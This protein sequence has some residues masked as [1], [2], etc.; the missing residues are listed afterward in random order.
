MNDQGRSVRVVVKRSVKYCVSYM[1]RLIP[2]AYFVK[3]LDSIATRYNHIQTNRK[4][5]LSFPR[6]VNIFYGIMPFEEGEFNGQS[7]LLPGGW[8]QHLRSR[9]GDYMQL[10]PEEERLG[11]RPYLLEFG[12]Y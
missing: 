7:V 1:L 11:H 5:N 9:Y 6:P 3:K 8:D 10:P 2:H 12:I 4:G